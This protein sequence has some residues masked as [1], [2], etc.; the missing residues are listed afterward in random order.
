MELEAIFGGSQ[1]I[2]LISL[3]IVLLDEILELLLFRLKIN[4]KTSVIVNSPIQYFTG[5]FNQN[6]KAFLQYK[7]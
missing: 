3:L 7:L 1:N 5:D 4:I 6:D 2:N